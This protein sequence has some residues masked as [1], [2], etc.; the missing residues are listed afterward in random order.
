MIKSAYIH[1]PFCNRICSYCD[2]CKVLYNKKYIND[3]LESLEKEINYLY[4]KDI[5]DTIYIGGGTPS[6]LSIIE[7]ETLFNILR[8]FKKSKNC[9]ITIEANIES[10]TIEKLKLFKKYGVNRL[11]IGLE[12]TNE[13]HL[14][15]LN[16]NINF[17]RVEELINTAYNLG[18]DNI[19]IDLMYGIKSQSISDIKKD[20][21]FVTKLGVKHISIYSLIIEEN[22]K[23]FIDKTTCIDEEIEANMYQYICNYLKELGYNHYEISNFSKDGYES[24][25]NLCYWSNCN[26]YGFGVG[27]SSYIDNIRESNNRSLT[28][29]LNNEFEKNTEILTK[30]DIMDYEVML[31]LRLKDGIDKK[32]FKSKYHKNIEEIY[33]YQ[34]LVDNN[35]L[36]EDSN[37]LYIKEDKLFISNEI[38]IHIEKR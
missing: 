22:T 38:I 30:D 8:T 14:K 27:A 23:L 24:R 11:S 1:I 3:Y 4:N 37:K 20:I 16:R 31:R 25:H 15:Y 26:Y 9:E 5:L 18:I 2:F 32:I 34:E 29:Y 12:S 35:L 6:S 13:K 21:D 33:S 28:K 7:L 36:I 10:L 19:N 17:K